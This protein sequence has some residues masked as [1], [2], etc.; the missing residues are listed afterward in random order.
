[1]NK[2]TRAWQRLS[3]DVHVHATGARIERRGYPIQ[4]GWYLVDAAG[5]RPTQYFEPTPQGCDRAFL[6]FES[7]QIPSRS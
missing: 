2:Q 7:R 4:H 6:T 3:Q 5:G 1:M